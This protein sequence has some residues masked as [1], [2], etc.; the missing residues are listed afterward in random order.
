MEKAVKNK[1]VK[2]IETLAEKI[3]GDIGAAD[4]LKYTQAALTTAH[5]LQVLSQTK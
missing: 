1:L 5:V 3:Q 2:A 4:A